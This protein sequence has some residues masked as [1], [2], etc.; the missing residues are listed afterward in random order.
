MFESDYYYYYYRIV[1]VTILVVWGMMQLVVNLLLL[2]HATPQPSTSQWVF[3]I[4]IA[5]VAFAVAIDRDTY[6]PHM[7]RA[8]LPVPVML[9]NGGA[10]KGSE[11]GGHHKVIERHDAVLLD[12]LPNHSYVVWWTMSGEHVLHQYGRTKSD[13]QGIAVVPDVDTCIILLVDRDLNRDHMMKR[14]TQ[15]NAYMRSA[16]EEGTMKLSSTKV[17]ITHLH[18]RVVESDWSLSAV[19]TKLL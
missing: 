18:Y 9:M 8:T 3:S 7:S 6:M 12:R 1:I 19:G 15:K 13:A 11:G 14:H 2:S 17:I 4:F 16:V 10:E 5:V